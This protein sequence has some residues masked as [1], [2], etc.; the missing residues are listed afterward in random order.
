MGEPTNDQFKAFRLARGLTQPDLA[1]LVCDYVEQRTGHRPGVDAQAI[2]RIECGEIAWPRRATRQALVAL[3]GS[4]SEAALG[5]YPKRTKRDAD[6]DEA[7]K[8][9]HFLA[10]AGLAAP[11]LGSQPPARVGA[12]DVD[13]M[14]RKFTKLEAMDSEYGGGDTFH[15]YFTELAR[16]EQILRSSNRRLAT[17]NSLIELAAQQAQQAGWAAFDAGFTEVAVALFNYSRSAAREVGSRA[18]EA[19]SLV[20]IAYA[21]G[22]SESIAAADAACVTLGPGAP[23]TAVALLQSRRAWSFATVGDMEAA[24][25]ALDIARASL[26]DEDDAPSWCAWMNHAELDIMAGRVWSVLH[27]PERAI[28]PLR[29]ALAAYPDTWARDKALYLTWLADAYFDAGDPNQ[30]IVATEKAFALAREVS[31][32][33]PLARVRETAQR[34]LAVGAAEAGDLARRAT[35]A[36]API[37]LQL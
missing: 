23:G 28:P 22:E 20:H 27:K 9:R 18:L 17:A 4:E 26:D 10:A 15:L 31:S 35:T 13:R 30:A 8:R 25:R 11:L 33:R 12:V 21:T 2:S 19:N 29:R 1:E 32:V 5:L 37:P 24:A 34:A 3:L 36:R 6:K 7:T 16:T 14:R